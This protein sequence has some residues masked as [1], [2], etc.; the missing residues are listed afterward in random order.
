MSR[1]TPSCPGSA[2]PRSP[3]AIPCWPSAPTPPRAAEAQARRGR[4]VRDGPDG[5]GAGARRRRRLFRAHLPARVPRLCPV[6][7][8]AADTRLVVGWLDTAQLAAVDATEPNYGR[9]PLSGDDCPMT[10]PSGERLAGAYLYVSVHGLLADGSGRSRCRA[11]GSR[12]PCSAAYW[13][14]RRGCAGCS[15]PTLARGW[16]GRAPTRRCGRRERARSRRRVGAAARRVPLG[17]WRGRRV[18]WTRRGDRCGGDGGGGRDEVPG[19]ARDAG[20]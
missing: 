12:V 15:G 17:R 1:W 9:I 16:R 4:A 19:G 18:R 5:A 2:W 20:P 6:P 14:A 8:P 3:G 13:P 10:L 11:A 7:G